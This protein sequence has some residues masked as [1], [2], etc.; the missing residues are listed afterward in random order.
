MEEVPC[1]T[2]L[3]PLA[4]PCY[5]LCLVGVE[6]EGFVDYQGRAGIISIVR[7]NLRSVILGVEMGAGSCYR[8]SLSNC[9]SQ[10]GFNCIGPRG[11]SKNLGLGRTQCTSQKVADVWKKD[12]WHF[13][14]FSQALLEP[15]K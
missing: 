3:A 11:A 10:P 2:S 12:V 1:R 7:W 14:A 15:E 13:Q 4:S 8:V 5:V 9:R 6:T